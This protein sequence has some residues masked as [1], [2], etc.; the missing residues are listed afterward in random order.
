MLDSEEP[1]PPS[2]RVEEVFPPDLHQL[3]DP[4]EPPE[5]TTTDIAMTRL[6]IA[7]EDEPERPQ[8]EEDLFQVLQKELPPHPLLVQFCQFHSCT[9]TE[10]LSSE[11]STIQMLN[12]RAKM[13]PYTWEDYKQLFPLSSEAISEY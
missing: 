11:P 13:L 4:D 7:E 2:S 8:A 12:E 6:E 1:T 9:V 10:A 3:G 5:V